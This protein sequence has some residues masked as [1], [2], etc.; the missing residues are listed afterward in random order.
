MILL[1]DNHP[2]NLWNQPMKHLFLAL[3]LPT[4]VSACAAPRASDSQILERL[5]EIRAMSCDAL[6]LKKLE[7]RAL[8]GNNGDIADKSNQMAD[9]ELTRRCKK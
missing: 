5:G 9:A 7:Y 4:I 3:A 2:F 8:A 1:K 6:Q